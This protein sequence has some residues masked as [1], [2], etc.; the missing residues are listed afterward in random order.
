VAEGVETE[1][2]FEFL[3]KEGCDKVQGFLY[4]APLAAEALERYLI[5]QR[6]VAR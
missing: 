1:E 4:S 3:R 5:G 6:A 2:Q